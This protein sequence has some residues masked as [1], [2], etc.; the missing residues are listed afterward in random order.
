MG[1]DG[2][3]RR[4][5]PFQ[6]PNGRLF[7][8]PR[9]LIAVPGAASTGC[10]WP[11]RAIRGDASR[12]PAPDR[13]GRRRQP[14]R[15]RGPR[16]RVRR[17]AV[18][19]GRLLTAWLTLPPTWRSGCCIRAMISMPSSTCPNG[20]SVP[21]LRRAGPGEAAAV[22][23]LLGRVHET[24]RDCGPVTW[25]TDSA[26]AWL[27]DPGLYAYL[28]EDGLLAYRWQRG[29]EELFVERAEAVSGQT[30]RALWTQLGSHASIA[31]RVYAITGSASPT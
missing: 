21:G 19:A 18:H 15:R 28:A 14:G 24:A 16:R 4:R 3:V 13:P 12:D 10:P 23:A 9:R 20:P 22:I 26:A 6:M 1:P 30:V 25:D 27:A 8:F 7:S 17:D 29:N 31:D 2:P 5:P 11:R